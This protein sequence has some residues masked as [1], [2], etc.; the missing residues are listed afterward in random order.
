M[1]RCRNQTYVL[2]LEHSTASAFGCPLMTNLL[3]SRDKRNSE[4]AGK[5]TTKSQA[6]VTHAC[7]H[8]TTQQHTMVVFLSHPS[9]LGALR[10]HHQKAQ[11]GCNDLVGTET[12]TTHNTNHNKRNATLRLALI[13]VCGLDVFV[14]VFNVYGFN[15]SVVYLAQSLR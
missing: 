6:C 3:E 13:C 11:T 1:E 5:R 10:I 7:K 12:H 8:T 14:L 4:E 2:V 15:H 9:H